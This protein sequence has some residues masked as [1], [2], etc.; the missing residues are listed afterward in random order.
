M[1]QEFAVRTGQAE[2]G[3]HVG[4]LLGEFP[5][6]RAGPI[7]AVG[8]GAF[9]L[10][11]GILGMGFLREWQHLHVWAVIL[12]VT[13]GTGFLVGAWRNENRL[14]V[15]SGGLAHRKGS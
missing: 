15:Y 11:L 6:L 9:L 10:G 8:A 3:R 1:I 7:R 5:D 2:A 12:L 13:G 4:Q 14:L